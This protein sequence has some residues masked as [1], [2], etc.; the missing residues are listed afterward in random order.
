MRALRRWASPTTA[1]SSSLEMVWKSPQVLSAILMKSTPCLHWRRTSVI[2]SATELA[3]HAVDVLGRAHPR[4]LVVGDAA[5]GDDEAPGAVDARPLDQA[6]VDRLAQRDVD[7]PGAAGNGQA[8]HTGTQHLPGVVRRPDGGEL[9]AGGAPRDVQPG[10]GRLAEGQVAVALDEA[11]HDPFAGGV[12]G[13]HALAVF[14]VHLRRN[15]ADAEDAVTLDHHG[16][17]LERRLARGVDQGAVADNSGVY[18]ICAHRVLLWV[19]LDFPVAALVKLSDPYLV[20][21]P[22]PLL[23]CSICALP[24]GLDLRI[25][26]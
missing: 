14:N 17:V 9:G 21:D 20:D 6:G 19:R 1:C 2:I 7:E 22:A 11:G 24:L 5:V 25:V 10:H 15:C 4:R 23:H 16:V 18:V 3:R 26:F 12:D 8:G 13:L